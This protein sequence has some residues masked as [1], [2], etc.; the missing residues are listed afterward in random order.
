MGYRVNQSERLDIFSVVETRMFAVR[1]V[2]VMRVF[3]VRLRMMV[4]V[5][6][7]VHVLRCCLMKAEVVVRQAD[8]IALNLQCEK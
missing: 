2:A 3:L 6:N 1:S 7:A 5:S 4:V 8:D